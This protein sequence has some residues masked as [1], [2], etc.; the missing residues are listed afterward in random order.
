MHLEFDVCM[1]SFLP[2]LS[3]QSKVLT[4]LVEFL[5]GGACAWVWR[6]FIIITMDPW[7]AFY[8]LGQHS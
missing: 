7:G 2:K 3:K 8:C 4:I 6:N 5:F 1:M